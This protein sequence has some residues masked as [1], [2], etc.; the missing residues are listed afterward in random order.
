VAIDAT[1]LLGH[2]TGVGR[3]CEGALGALATVP[4]LDMDAF[5]VTWRR[6]RRLPP[7]VP[8]GVD[9]GQRAMPAR[10]LHLA[11]AHLRGPAL[12]WFVGPADVVHG[13][14]FVV[15]PTR[16]AARVVTVHD[17]T[18]VRY[19]E[20]C[21]RSTMGFP[22]M[23]RRAVASGAWVHTP[24]RFVADEVVAEFAVDPGRVRVVYHGVPSARGPGATTSTPVPV[25]DLPTGTSRY[26]LAVGTVEPRKDYPGLVRAFDLVAGACPDVALVIAGADGWGASAF[27][28]ALEASPWRHR[29][30]QLGYID[31]AAL[32]RWLAGAAVLA[33]PSVYE[34]FGFPPLEA[35]AAG[36]PVVASAAG[37]VPEIVGDGAVLVPP[38]DVEALGAALVSVLGDADGRDALVEKGRR[39][40]TQFTWDA[41]GA[42]LA[43]LYVDAARER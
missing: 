16:R 32:D 19:P 2:R 39:R 35:M 14:N 10:P 8:P 21:D 42:G 24:S 12:E 33:F 11:W 20:L 34:G 31:N 17:L 40:A 9:V 26:V 30:R 1:P 36:V 28:E 22:R 13:T 3:F 29:I 41:C 4:E 7:L 27:H 15:P 18:T 25:V 5:A 43:G 6:R 23:V 38:R 37:A